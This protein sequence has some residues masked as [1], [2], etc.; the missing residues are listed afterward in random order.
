MGYK[1]GVAQG[2][3]DLAQGRKYEPIKVWNDPLLQ[4]VLKEILSKVESIHRA[5]VKNGFEDGIMKGYGE[6]YF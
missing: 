2:K 5:E 6:T 3:D 4:A 1:A